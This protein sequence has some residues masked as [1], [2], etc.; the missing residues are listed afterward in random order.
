MGRTRLFY[1]GQAAD[2]LI[3]LEEEG[4]CGCWEHMVM[5]MMG[6]E[7]GARILR[8]GATLRKKQ[9]GARSQTVPRPAVGVVG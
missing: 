9:A 1:A 8:V 2:G 4:E 7:G 6:D 3:E 5:G